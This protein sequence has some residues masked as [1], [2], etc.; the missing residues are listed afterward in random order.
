[1]SD[2]RQVA[3]AL[4]CFADEKGAAKARKPFEA[5]LQ[6]DGDA[7]LQTTI[8]KVNAKRKA[9]VHDPRRVLAGTLTAALTWGLFGLVAGTNKIESA[10]AWAV[11]G[12]LCGGAYAYAAEHRLTKSELARI[13][14]Q[15]AP[16]SSALITYAKVKDPQ[17]LLAAAGA[18]TPSTASVA[19]IAPDLA[20]RVFAG[21]TSPL[22]VSHRSVG[23]TLAPAETSVL[24]M[25]LLRYSDPKAAAHVAAQLAKHKGANGANGHT[26][27]IELVIETDANGHRHVT[28]PGSGTAAW[29]R[30]DT[31]SWGAFGLVWGVI[32][33]ATGGDGI[34]GFLKDGLVTGI[35]WA[36][37]G[38]VA[39]ALYGLWAGRSI[40]ARRLEGIGPIL[41]PGTSTVLAWGEGALHDA[42]L[43][44]LAGPGAEHFVLLFNPVEDGAVL[45]A[46]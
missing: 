32:V 25:V 24:S 2:D 42:D 33:G 38:L 31:I 1:M 39:G 12:A 43:E 18:L 15:L 16:S 44:P 26:P 8:L 9:S 36:I 5:T 3:V 41:A 19:T 23:A 37:F 22:E 40:S 46:A 29:A 13:G 7:A 10:I 14:R 27:E 6:S 45:E 20:A 21:T 30:S 4:L 17:R 34:L 28:D 11:I 35:G